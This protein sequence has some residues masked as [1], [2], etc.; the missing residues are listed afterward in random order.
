MNY[1]ISGFDLFPDGKDMKILAVDP[2]TYRFLIKKCAE[3]E[4]SAEQKVKLEVNNIAVK[5]EPFTEEDSKDKVKDVVLERLEKA[6]IKEVEEGE[7]WEEKEKNKA[8]AEPDRT[9]SPVDVG[10]VKI[11]QESTSKGDRESEYIIF[12]FFNVNILHVQNL[13]AYTRY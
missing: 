8:G 1:N 2:N 13:M 3:D 4:A 11:K 12:A 7:E 9:V 5:G 6:E 10:K